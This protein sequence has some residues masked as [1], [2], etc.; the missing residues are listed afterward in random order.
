[1]RLAC[2]RQAEVGLT[3]KRL[4]R[5][6]RKSPILPNGSD[7]SFGGSDTSWYAPSYTQTFG[8]FWLGVG[9]MVTLPKFTHLDHAHI[10]ARVS[11]TAT[12][13]HL[14]PGWIWHI[15]EPAPQSAPPASQLFDMHIG[16]LRHNKNIWL[17]F[18]SKICIIEGV[19]SSSALSPLV[20]FAVE[21]RGEVSESNIWWRWR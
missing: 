7:S 21:C 14:L 6:P 12:Y 9:A 18:C 4:C 1:M 2:A 17:N 20:S 5:F 13:Y 3:Q 19:S 11:T 16:L 8:A 10:C 15:M